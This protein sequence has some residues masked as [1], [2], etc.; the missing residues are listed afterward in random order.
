MFPL[1]EK[2]G[3]RINIANSYFCI[4]FD[5]AVGYIVRMK[6]ITYTPSALKDLKKAPA[7]IRNRIIAKMELFAEEPT[8]L[9]GNLKQLKGTTKVTYRLR[10]G[11]WRVIF[12]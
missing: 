2:S 9:K 12:T 8:S 11:D 6:K 10:V 4:A 7:N 5:I 3:V 1:L